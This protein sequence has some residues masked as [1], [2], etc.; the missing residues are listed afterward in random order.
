MSNMQKLRL[1]VTT[2]STPWILVLSWNAGIWLSAELF[3]GVFAWQLPI[4]ETWIATALWGFLLLLAWSL[5]IGY[6][7]LCRTARPTVHQ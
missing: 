2:V 7:W 5:G 6:A 3:G 4:R 1:F